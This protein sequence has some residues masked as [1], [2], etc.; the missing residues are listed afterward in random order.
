MLALAIDSS[1]DICSLTL[2]GESGAIAEY[3]FHHKMNLLRR[4]L[5]NIH[6]LLQDSGVSPGDLE[7]I[8]TSLGPGSFTGLRIGVTVAKSLAY[9]LSKPIIGIGT[10]DALAHG[11]VPTRDDLI[12]PMIFA[13]ADEVYWSPFDS[14]GTRLADYEVSPVARALAQLKA[15]GSGVC[16]CGTGARRNTERIKEALRQYATF[17]P[18]RYDYVRGA[19]LLELGVRRVLAGEEDDPLPLAPLYVRRPTPVVRLEEKGR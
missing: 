11:I 7:C 15:R 19:V 10:L 8:I 14:A 4:I 13:R 9:V 18:P 6:A 16:F 1:Q 12:C 3:D 2:G 17:A 5:R